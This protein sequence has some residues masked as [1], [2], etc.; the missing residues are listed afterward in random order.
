MIIGICYSEQA[1]LDR[2]VWRIA[3]SGELE[4]LIEKARAVHMTT[5]DKER[6]RRSFAFGNTA[7]ENSRITRETIEIEAEALEAK[8]QIV[9]DE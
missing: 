8:E 7:F 6:Q 2:S 5:E 3:M 9:R 4:R 1:N